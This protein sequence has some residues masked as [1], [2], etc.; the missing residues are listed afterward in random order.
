MWLQ[1]SDETS[2]FTRRIDLAFSKPE[3]PV[4]PGRDTTRAAARCW[5][6]ELADLACCGNASNFARRIDL[7]FSKPEG[8]IRSSCDAVKDV[9]G[10]CELA[11][12]A[13]RSDP[14]NLAGPIIGAS[15]CEPDV[16]IWPCSDGEREFFGRRQ[17]ELADLSHW[18]D[19]PN[20]A[21]LGEPE[22]PIW[23][24]CDAERAS[25]GRR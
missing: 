14:P 16:P 9:M 6:R 19:A 23:S 22:V 13:L 11:D 1:P 10:Q 15:V 25:M 17:G 24:R 20:V 3:G 21:K 5:Q 7:A 12:L 18:G 8:I 4:R 2:N